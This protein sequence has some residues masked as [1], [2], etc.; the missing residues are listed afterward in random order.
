MDE[1]EIEE[2]PEEEQKKEKMSIHAKLDAIKQNQMQSGN[3]E[4]PGKRDVSIG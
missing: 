4:V 3:R 1:K 2:E